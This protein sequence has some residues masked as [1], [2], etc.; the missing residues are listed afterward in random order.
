MV[1]RPFE[2]DLHGLGGAPFSDA[3]GN[4]VD[5]GQEQQANVIEGAVPDDER[6]SGAVVYGAVY[7]DRRELCPEA[8]PGGW[9]RP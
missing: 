6:L 3:N 2:P 5:D 8:L 7:T 1:E 9:T 4:G